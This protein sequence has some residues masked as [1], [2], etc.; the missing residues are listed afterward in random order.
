MTNHGRGNVTVFFICTAFIVFFLS[1]P[2]LLPPYTASANSAVTV[3]E[4]IP[5]LL[6][7]GQLV[8]EEISKS[9][10]VSIS[11]LLGMTAM[12]AYHYW[13]TPTEERRHLKWHSSPY[14][15]GPMLVI[16]L[17]CI[18]KDS[19]KTA[20]LIPKPILVPLD[21]LE[22]VEN[23]ISGLI[24]ILFVLSSM[25]AIKP[26]AATALFQ[27][28]IVSIAY[29]GDALSSL[30]DP[31]SI[32]KTTLIGAFAIFCFLVVWLVSH[33]INILILLCPFSSIDFL[34][35][36][37]RNTVLVILLA[38]TLIHPYLGLAVS[39]VIVF[40]AYLAAGRSFRFMV[41]GSLFSF[42]I[43]LGR[44]TEYSPNN[45]K[46][47]AFTGEDLPDVPA[48]S[49]GSLSRSSNA[50]LEFT[51]RPWLI[52]PERRIN[53]QQLSANCEIGRG[54]ISPIVLKTRKKHTSYQTLF[55]LRPMYK[56]HEKSVAH[57]LGITTIRDVAV[58]K[59][60]K[61]GW[62]WLKKQLNPS[63]N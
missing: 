42:D 6:T 13:T 14:F 45:S 7:E 58:G 53:T 35:K 27:K 25:S 31:L 19:A 10:G 5:E 52:F 60:V 21:V 43:L 1:A 30:P 18:A 23:K 51:Y 47:H 4:Q 41:F 55:R 17:A 8:A 49:Y 20:L 26:G 11:P 61:E 32:I 38:A 62:G 34:L 50:T 48:M 2:W 12:G 54:T 59:G 29:A 3:E 28:S 44:S 39:L 36:M 56:S 15:W 9:V 16:L 33:T 46:I 22:A 63:N 40:L 57:S 37:A 24:G